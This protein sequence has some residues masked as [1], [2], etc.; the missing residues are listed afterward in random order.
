MEH[1][2]DS[3]H[4]E[5]HSRRPFAAIFL[6]TLLVVGSG[7]FQ[8]SAMLSVGPDSS[9][10]R[11]STLATTIVSFSASPSRAYVGDTVTFYAN[12]TSDVSS[13]L[14][15][16]V[17]FDSLLPSLANNTASA[18]F[19]TDTSNPGSVVT[20]YTYD[21]LGNLSGSS[22]TYFRARLY[23]GDGVD[24]VTLAISVYIVENAAPAFTL[25]LP[26]GLQISPDAEYTFNTTV[27]DVDD[28]ELTVTWDFGDGSAVAVNSTGPAA[29][30]VT[31][32]QKH[33][34]SPYLEPGLG[35]YNIYYWMNITVDDGQGHTIQST[36]KLT[37]YIPWNWSPVS[38]F[39]TNST[40]VDP[41]DLVWLHANATDKEGDP[42]TWTYEFSN[43][44]EVYHTEVHYSDASTPNS[45]VWM[46]ITHTFEVEGDYTVT[47]WLSDVLSP[48][49]QVFPH[50]L[51]REVNLR[52]E[53][54]EAPYVLANI[55][56]S[57]SVIYYNSTV[58]VAPVELS[59]QA[60]DF[61]G[62]VL[63]V[64]WDF[65]DG[66]EQVV[67]YS[68]GGIQVY[69]F[70]QDHD[71]TD[72]GIYNVS[73]TVTDGREG[74]GTT[75]YGNLVVR[76][77]NSAPT[78]RALLLEL[79][80]SNFAVVNSTVVLTL[81]IRDAELDPVDIWWTFGDNSSVVHSSVDEYGSDGNGTSSVEHVYDDL[82]AF[83]VQIW[84]TDNKFDYRWHNSS[85]NATVSV[86][87]VWVKEIVVWDLWD[88]T[89]LTLFIG[90]FAG[91][92][93]FALY[94]R[95]FRKKLDMKGLS[96]EEYKILKKELR[97]KARVASGAKA[98]GDKKG[99]V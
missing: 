93:V 28:D 1:R 24:T 45:T 2:A 84:F 16:T 97:A 80:N 92:F 65:G 82:G 44:T 81:V 64:T 38:T 21:H 99:G 67:E 96:Y 56:F 34:W 15:F 41:T 66:S 51:S 40:M 72:S 11:S 49:L 32:R 77:N 22:G 60:N 46:N 53:A 83:A 90:S 74:H 5:N 75:R 52:S 76:S 59:I 98:G 3:A 57:P 27:M 62:D 63:T 23:V 10:Q 7:F 54:N 20:T 12:A 61:D 8:A 94:M 79:S 88:Y 9:E 47:L 70:A 95:R 14:H 25:Q 30:G 33:T 55:T 42:L 50:N 87:D 18:V 39:W 31:V 48:D 71:Y 86:R 35:D 89:S 6:A 68:A 36:T 85:W 58:G 43:G 37:I 78:V 19:E 91:V 13:A 4:S 73:C 29:S 69:T 17:Y 26:S